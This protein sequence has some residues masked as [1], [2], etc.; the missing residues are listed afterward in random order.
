MSIEEK[1]EFLEKKT[2]VCLDGISE[3]KINW[4]IELLRK[5]F[6]LLERDLIPVIRKD[7][8]NIRN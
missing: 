7:I 2:G 5:P 8:Y 3:D 1:R 4:Y 6:P